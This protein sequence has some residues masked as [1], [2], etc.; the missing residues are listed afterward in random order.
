MDESILAVKRTPEGLVAVV[1][2]RQND[3]WKSMDNDNLVELVEMYAFVEESQARLKKLWPAYF[4]DNAP[5]WQAISQV[6]AWDADLTYHVLRVLLATVPVF[7]ENNPHLPPLDFEAEPSVIKKTAANPRGVLAKK[8]KKQKPKSMPKIDLRP[9]LCD[10]KHVSA[11]LCKLKPF[12][13]EAVARLRKSKFNVSTLAQTP[14]FTTEPYLTF[15]HSGSG[16]V[17]RIDLPRNFIQYLMFW[18][19]NLP[20]K[21]VKIFLSLYYELGLERDEILLGAVARL[22][23]Y[24]EPEQALTW[25]EIT[26]DLPAGKRYSFLLTLLE[27]GSDELDFENYPPEQIRE[28]V[29]MIP[30]KNLEVFLDQMFQTFNNKVSIQYLAG[31][32]RF[33]KKF[34]WTHCLKLQNDCPRYPAKEVE[35]LIQRLE[36]KKPWIPMEIWEGFGA[37]KDWERIILRPEWKQYSIKT[38]RKFIALIICWA[39]DKGPGEVK[40]RNAFEF[41]QTIDKALQ[42]IPPDYH[43]GLFYNLDAVYDILDNKEHF[44]KHLKPIC[45]LM[46]RLARKPFPYSK[47]NFHTPIGIIIH[48]TQGAVRKQFLEAPDASFLKLDKICKTDNKQRLTSWGLYNLVEQLPEFVVTSFIHFPS[49]LIKVSGRLG[50]MSFYNR[51]ETVK[52]FSQH[53]LLKINVEKVSPKRLYSLI[54]KYYQRG[55]THPVPKKLQAHFKGE[56][57]LSEARILGYHEKSKKNFLSF[58][59][60]VLDQHILDALSCFHPAAKEKENWEHALQLL[61]WVDTNR[62]GFKNFLKAYF[63]GDNH[64]VENHPETKKWF[65]KHKNINKELWNQG[66]LFCRRTEKYG[67]VRIELESDPLEILK[68][69]TYVGS[70][71]SLGGHYAYSAVAVL[72][73]L[74][75]QVLYARDSNG[76]VLGR[77]LVAL[78]EKDELVC[79]DVYPD[80][81]RNDI[82]NLF[83]EYDIDFAKALNIDLYEGDFSKH[84]DGYPVRTI[85]SKEWWNDGAWYKIAPIE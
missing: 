33:A 25:L 23:A 61:N 37:H 28:L 15:H 78:S 36:F 13:P 4:K 63:G 80:N 50:S 83:F 17:K 26:R 72:L 52:Q 54:E 11:L 53:Q 42:A 41:M 2:R 27:T 82:K 67:P 22:L 46:I 85:L 76:K 77:Q 55:M 29:A 39:E 24:S 3:F 62:R 75:K 48:K 32:F 14:R 74:N 9:Y 71:L 34:G 49:K 73:D 66:I 51:H 64:Y 5:S 47:L 57:K 8:G 10:P 6:R 69:G 44:E 7:P 40:K 38:A 35:N 20:W 43:S 21:K 68:M 19:S 58:V 45:D 31:G 30:Y 18:L 1:S 79:F 16:N 56:I 81:A 65:A 60:D 59:L 70:C 84:E 12:W